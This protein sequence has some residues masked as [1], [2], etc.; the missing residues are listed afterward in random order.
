MSIQKT[1]EAEKELQNITENLTPHLI[2]IVTAVS[3]DKAKLCNDEIMAFTLQNEC[4][5][6][7]VWKFGTDQHRHFFIHS[8]STASDLNSFENYLTK[9]LEMDRYDRLDSVFNF[10]K[11][12]ERSS[13]FTLHELLKESRATSLE[14]TPHID[15]LYFPINK[16]GHWS[17]LVISVPRRT[18]LHLDSLYNAEHQELARSI[19][20]MLTNAK[21][22]MPLRFNLIMPRTTIQTSIWECGWCV[23][24]FAKWFRATKIETDFSEVRK[25][26]LSSTEI[27]KI[28]KRI[29]VRCESKDRL[30][31]YSNR[32]SNA[33]DSLEKFVNKEEQQK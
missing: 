25:I 28:A 30:L 4:N 32:L 7:P 3:N 29:L 17:L 12:G 27:V 10:R 8:Q 13:L 31:S 2:S 11:F 14:N 1:S 18:A 5:I 20:S 22:I 15:S 24:L 16:S 33:Y 9:L 23:M 21:L 6:Q 26:S 19:M